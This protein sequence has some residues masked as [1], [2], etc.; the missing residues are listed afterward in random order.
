MMLEENEEA[1]IATL[2]AALNSRFKIDI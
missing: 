2:K 1:F